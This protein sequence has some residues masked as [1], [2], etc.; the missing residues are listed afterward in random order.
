MFL[1]LNFTCAFFKPQKINLNQILN[2]NLVIK[3][4]QTVLTKVDSVKF[5][6]VHIDDDLKWSVHVNT[7]CKDLSKL[8]G[9]FYNIKEFIPL[10]N[11]VN[12]NYAYIYSKL[13][14]GLIVYGFAAKTCV[15]PLQV[16]VNR[17][18]RVLQSSPI[19]TSRLVLYE[20]YNTMSIMNLHKSEIFKLVHTAIY[21]RQT[22]PQCIFEMIITNNNNPSQR[23]TRSANNDIQP[24]ETLTVKKFKIKIIN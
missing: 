1:S 12:L 10:S 11:R 13:M 8:C 9:W 18:L 20:R 24:N 7:L 3:L 14:Y 4:H 21:N 15:Q 6:G 16:I 22:L 23:N 19:D 2:D 17:I 5:L